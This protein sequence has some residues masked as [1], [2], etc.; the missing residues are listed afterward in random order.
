VFGRAGGGRVR[1][2][3]PAG[4]ATPAVGAV[5]EVDVVESVPIIFAASTTTSDPR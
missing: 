4:M 1:V 2:T 5:L 3:L